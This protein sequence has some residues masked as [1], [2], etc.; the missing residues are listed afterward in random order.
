VPTF[1]SWRRSN[2]FASPEPQIVAREL[3]ERRAAHQF[4]VP[5]DFGPHQSE[6][7]LHAR[8]VALAQP[9]PEECLFDAYS[10]PSEWDM[11]QTTEWK[12]VVA[13]A[14]GS[15]V[16]PELHVLIQQGR[17]L[18]EKRKLVRELTEVFVRNFEVA[19]EAVV[20]QIVESAKG[21]RG[22][23]RWSAQRLTGHSLH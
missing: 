23:R 7:P 5:L 4:H 12:R 2:S 20:I 16:M 22:K 21:S 8:P 1:R 10:A 17:T 18:D 15:S 19:P 6:G 11:L 14:W 3:A 9:L 13:I